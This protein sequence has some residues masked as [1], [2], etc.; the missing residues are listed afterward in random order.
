MTPEQKRQ[1]SARRV[2]EMFRPA[3]L[4]M[5]NAQHVDRELRFS[6]WF[7]CNAPLTHEVAAQIE[8]I[9]QRKEWMR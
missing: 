5:D 8:A 9:G 3:Q 1:E 2:L 4:E 7:L 6:A